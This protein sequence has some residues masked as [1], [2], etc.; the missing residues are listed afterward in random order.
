MRMCEAFKC[1]RSLKP[2]KVSNLEGLCVVSAFLPQFVFPLE[3]SLQRD[4][5]S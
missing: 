1:K 4:L 5:V 3:V 2:K